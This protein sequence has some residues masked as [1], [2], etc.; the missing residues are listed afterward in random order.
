MTIRQSTVGVVICSLMVVLY[1]C[2]M[3][4]VRSFAANIVYD[5]A[6]YGR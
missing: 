3:A 2:N 1:R 4:I 5:H 6:Q